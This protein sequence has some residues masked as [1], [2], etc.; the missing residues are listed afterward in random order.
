M[1]GGGDVEVSAEMSA[2]ERAGD[3][4]VDGGVAGPCVRPKTSRTF[5]RHRTADS[6]PPSQ[7][8][9]PFPS[10]RTSASACRSVNRANFAVGRSWPSSRRGT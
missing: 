9:D 4:D 7:H 2:N 10:A 1:G 6:A 3:G 8:A 5:R